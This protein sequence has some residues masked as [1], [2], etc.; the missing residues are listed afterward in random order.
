MHMKMRQLKNAKFVS[1]FVVALLI[2]SSSL[3]YAQVF[4]DVADDHWASEYIKKMNRLG[5]ITGYDDATFRP[6][7]SVTKI[8]AVVMMARLFDLQ[9]DEKDEM[10]DRYENFFEEMDIEP[11]YQEGLAIALSKG[12][13]SKEVV[14]KEFYEDGKATPAE[15]AEICI[16]LTRA[17]G[18]EEEAKNKTIIYLPF[19]DVELIP[20]KVQPYID[21]MVDKGVIN[22]KGDGEGKFNPNST[23]TRAI[24]AKMLSVAYDYIDENDVELDTVN[25][26]GTTNETKVEE[27]TTVNGTISGLIKGNTEVYMTI[28]D[29]DGDKIAYIVNED[30]D[31][32]IDGKDA[33][34]EDLEEGLIVEAEVTEEHNVVT[35][36]AESVI[37]EYSGKL[38]SLI[39]FDPAMLTIEYKNE[40]D[41]T[42][43]KG[44]YIADEV[45][46]TLDGEEADI[47]DISEGDIIDIE[48]KNNRVEKIDAES[49]YK[50]I[51]GNIVEV[52]FDPEPVLVVK[53]EDEIIHEYLIDEDADIERNDKNVELTDLRKGDEVEV[54]IEYNIITDIEAEVVEGEDE[55]II[56]AILIF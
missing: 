46:I 39:I 13:V 23:V 50:E 45:E 48:V 33:D 2:L 25:N 28:K 14:E 21:V 56:K 41:E 47:D 26:N 19:T 10:K 51:E 37:E 3:A 11:W 27:T 44:F 43:T 22:S 31:I 53:D 8:Q 16:Y 49:R 4:T 24:M 35:L 1:L 36:K 7:D 32:S 18:L 30:T 6:N 55:G 42:Q 12:I 34:M 40:E 38:K 15:K 52:K 20:S 9:D 29:E 17:M 54:K 5:I